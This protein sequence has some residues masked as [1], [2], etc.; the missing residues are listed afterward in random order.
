[1]L[2]ARHASQLASMALVID[3]DLQVPPSVLERE[4]AQAVGRAILGRRSP[5]WARE[6]AMQMRRYMRQK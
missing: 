6:T 1:M 2:D 5:A 4:P 3:M